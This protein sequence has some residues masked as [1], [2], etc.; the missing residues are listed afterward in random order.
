MTSLLKIILY[1]DTGKYVQLKDKLIYI[2]H[3]PKLDW[4]IGSVENSKKNLKQIKK[5]FNKVY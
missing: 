5:R 2:K 4:I 1:P 3:V